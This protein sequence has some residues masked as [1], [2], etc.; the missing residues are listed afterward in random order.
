MCCVGCVRNGYNTISPFFIICLNRM[1]HTQAVD[2][3]A[4]LNKA[5]NNI[6]IVEQ[7]SIENC[8]NKINA[9]QDAKLSNQNLVMELVQCYIKPV[10]C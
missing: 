10:S 6:A 9:L 1:A 7:K 5:I 3:L 2:D 8:T 4:Y